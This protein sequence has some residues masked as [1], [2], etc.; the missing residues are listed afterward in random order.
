MDATKHAGGRPPLPLGTR[1]GATLTIR[2]R[3]DQKAAYDATAHASGVKTA[4]W[5]KQTLDNA[6]LKTTKS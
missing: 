4:A 6:A 1:A 3:E 5:I 2:L